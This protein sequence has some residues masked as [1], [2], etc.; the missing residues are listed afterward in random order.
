M[1]QDGALLAT[2]LVGAALLL[3]AVSDRLARSVSR[4]APGLAVLPLL[5]AALL[6]V[7]VFGEDSYRGNGVSRWD[8]YRS[9][10]GAL[11]AMYVLAVALMAV[12][13][14]V[15][16]YAGLQR[17]ERLLRLTALGGAIVA[18]VLVPATIVGFSL[19]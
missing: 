12:C 10:G 15:L 2:L 19:N 7:Y 18:L 17:R 5:T 8:A 11:G 3:V 1:S 9:P 13:A 16:V 6:S 4:Y 14:A